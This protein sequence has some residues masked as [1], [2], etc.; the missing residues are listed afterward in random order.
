MRRFSF[1]LVLLIL[2]TSIVGVQAQRPR[3]ERHIIHYFANTDWTWAGDVQTGDLVRLRGYGRINLY[4][5]CW[6]HQDELPP[7][8]TCRDMLV[9][10]E[11]MIG[12]PAIPG[13]HLIEE[14]WAAGLIARIDGGEP[15]VVGRSLRFVAETSG[16]LEIRINDPEWATQDDLGRWVVLVR[17]YGWR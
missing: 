6:E 8:V 14:G 15:F 12:I 2:L 4:P 13:T 16:V 11:G 9:S 17:I 3:Q 1:V 7:D 5:D 10:P